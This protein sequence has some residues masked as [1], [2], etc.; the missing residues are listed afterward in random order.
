M[1]PASDMFDVTLG[2][3]RH[4]V[5]RDV[6]AAALELTRGGEADDAAADDGRAAACCVERHIRGHRPGA[7]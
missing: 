1:K 3:H 2:V 6:E 7:P 4:G 5:D